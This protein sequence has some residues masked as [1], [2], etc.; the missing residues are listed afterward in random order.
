[1]GR[2]SASYKQV[3]RESMRTAAA[4]AERRHKEEM[5]PW[6]NG[7]GQAVESMHNKNRALFDALK[8]GDSLECFGIAGVV[9]KKNAKSVV[10]ELGSRYTLKEL[11]CCRITI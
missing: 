2:P 10:T 5:R 9:A 11:G 1:M 8:V 4:E 7:N 6:L 3:H